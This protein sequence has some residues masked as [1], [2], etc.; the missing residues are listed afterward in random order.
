MVSM[1]HTSTPLRN[2]FELLSSFLQRLFC[3]IPSKPEKPFS[4]QRWYW[5]ARCD[6]LHIYCALNP[7]VVQNIETHFLHQDPKNTATI[8]MAALRIRQTGQNQP[9]RAFCSP[10]WYSHNRGTLKWMDIRLW[11]SMF[12][13]QQNEMYLKADGNYRSQSECGDI[14][15]E[16]KF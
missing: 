8:E 12:Q 14:L 1:I 3:S 15:F 13:E 2:L 16:D 4:F 7:F 10:T 9:S 5:E 11:S 6:L